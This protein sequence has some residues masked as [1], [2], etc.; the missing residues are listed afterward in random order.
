ML[1][2]IITQVLHR[3][4]DTL[5]GMAVR[6]DGEQG[7]PRAALLADTHGLAVDREVGNLINKALSG[8]ATTDGP[9]S[10]PPS[11]GTE[12]VSW[13]DN[14]GRDLLKGGI[15]RTDAHRLNLLHRGAGILVRNKKVSNLI[16][17]HAP[18]LGRWTRM[19]II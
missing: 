18:Y 9:P 6:V 17:F 15:R 11:P 12:M 1:C 10:P 5:S 2:L 16:S 14:L 13:V 7:P 19:S 4:T 8:G 3:T